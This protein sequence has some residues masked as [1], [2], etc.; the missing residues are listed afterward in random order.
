MDSPVASVEE[1][2][3]FAWEIGQVSLRNAVTVAERMFWWNDMA[4]WPQYLSQKRLFFFSV[5]LIEITLFL[6]SSR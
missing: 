2:H 3:L 6:V 4:E 1:F 5:C